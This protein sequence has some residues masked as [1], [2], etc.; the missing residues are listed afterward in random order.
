MAQAQFLVSVMTLL[1]HALG[2]FSS[3][4][5]EHIFKVALR[6]HWRGESSGLTLSWGT[7]VDLCW[8]PGQHHPSYLTCLWSS[9]GQGGSRQVPTMPGLSLLSLPHPCR[10]RPFLSKQNTERESVPTL[11]YLGT[12]KHGRE[13]LATSPTTL[14]SSLS[15]WPAPA[16]DPGRHP[17]PASSLFIYYQRL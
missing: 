16:S 4:C 7:L 15:F 8:G 14:L 1:C 2:S 12:P 17:A 10:I 6:P 13:G 9:R 3:C 11:V 5:A